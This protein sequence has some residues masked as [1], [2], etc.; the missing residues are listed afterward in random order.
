ME[1]SRNS[2]VCEGQFGILR[3]TQNKGSRKGDKAQPLVQY[4]Q[5]SILTQPIREEVSKGS[6]IVWEG[7]Q[8][9]NSLE[10]DG[11][12]KGN[13]GGNE[14]KEEIANEQ[15]SA[16]GYKIES[17]QEGKKVREGNGTVGREE[18]KESYGN[19]KVTRGGDGEG[20]R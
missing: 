3:A 16:E 4:N 5:D 14:N 6:G 12:P 13:H 17:R 9:I 1:D 11:E 7:L 18:Q 8:R 19:K 10:E 20:R 15:K 2:H